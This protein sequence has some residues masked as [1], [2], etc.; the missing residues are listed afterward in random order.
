M[1]QAYLSKLLGLVATTLLVSSVAQAQFLPIGPTPIGPPIGPPN[2]LPGVGVLATDP[3]AL[4][5]TSSGAFTVIVPQAPT[6]DLNVVLKIGGTGSNTVDYLLYTNG[7]VLPTNVVTIPAGYLAVDILVQPIA[8]TVNTGNKTVVLTVETNAAYNVL[9]GARRAVV[10]IVDDVFNVPPPTVAITNPVDGS[11]FL[12]GTPISIGAEAS[13][14]GAAIKSV[15]FFANDFFLGSSTT[16][17]YSVTWSNPPTG[18][19]TLSALAFDVVGQSTLSAPVK[20]SVTNTLPVIHLSSP[21]NFSN[22]VLGSAVP[23]EA[24]SSDAVNPITNVT[25]YANARVIDSIAIPSSST[26]PYTNT[27]SWVPAKASVYL[28]QA[29]ATDSEGNKVFSNRVFI[30]VSKP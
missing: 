22:F 6:N 5:G 21:T 30:D 29:S 27:F 9:P 4:E 26:S 19:F 12:A 18:H 15:T 3:T 11:T 7:V 10:T 13:D 14:S 25:F 8:E 23:L 28:L 16:A 2:G 17:P 20:I 24:D 1:K